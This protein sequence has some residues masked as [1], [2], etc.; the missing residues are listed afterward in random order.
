MPLL[1]DNRRRL[2]KP[3]LAGFMALLLLL[4]GV[5]ASDEGAHF[6]LHHGKSSHHATCAVCAVAKGLVDAP[7]PSVTLTTHT[8]SF[9]WAI[10]FFDSVL[11]QKTDFS[12]ASSRG[13]PASTSSL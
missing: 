4:L 5:L 10:P 2:L 11:V 3:V 9:A 12:V 13:P 1:Y 7:S 6:K 8:L